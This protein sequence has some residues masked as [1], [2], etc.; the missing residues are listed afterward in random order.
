MHPDCCEHWA[1]V[2]WSHGV[3]VPSHGPV[4]V[5]KVQP[6]CW[7]QLTDDVSRVH[8]VGVPVQVEL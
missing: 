8:V 5:T 6:G 3:G 4:P 1:G 2:S 7:L